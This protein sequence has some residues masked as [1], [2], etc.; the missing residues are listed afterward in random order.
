MKTTIKL[1]VVLALAFATFSQHTTASAGDIFK[2]KGQGAQ[3]YFSSTDGCVTTDVFVFANDGKFQS[4]PGPGSPSSGTFLAISQYDW[5]NDELLLA[6]DGFADLAAGDFEVSRQLSSATLNATV[7]MYNYLTDST[8]DVFVDLTWTGSGPLF[9]QMS[10]SHFQ[11]PG[12]KINER[13][14]GT[15]RSAVAS[16]SV[17]DGWTNFAPE[18][19]VWAEMFSTQSGSVFVGCN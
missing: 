9:R 5:C 12:C 19:S 3:A 17:S 8:F 18:P 13:F 4:P 1:L 7:T 6:A 2:F 11:F 16:G 10:N 15:F 14:R